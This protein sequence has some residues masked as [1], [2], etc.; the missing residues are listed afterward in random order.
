M[1]FWA[2]GARRLSVTPDPFVYVQA[3]I[4]AGN[5]NSYY[6]GNIGSRFTNMVCSG[7]SGISDATRMRVALDSALGVEVVDAAGAM[8]THLTP[9]GHLRMGDGL[10]IGTRAANAT[11]TPDRCYQLYDETA[12]L[13][14]TYI[15]NAARLQVGWAGSFCYGYFAPY[16][17]NTGVVGGQSQRWADYIG[18]KTVQLHDG[19]YLHNCQVQIP[20]A[21]QTHFEIDVR[22]WWL[23]LSGVGCTDD[24]TTN[25]SIATLISAVAVNAVWQ[26]HLK[27]VGQ[28]TWQ[29]WIWAIDG[30]TLP[31]FQW[32]EFSQAD[33]DYFKLEKGTNANTIKITTL[34]SVTAG[35][36]T[37]DNLAA[38]PAN[39]NTHHKVTMAA[40]AT[41]TK[42][43]ANNTL[44][45]TSATHPV[46]MTITMRG[47]ITA[48]PNGGVSKTVYCD[49]LDEWPGVIV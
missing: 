49:E 7:Y 36:E 21:I 9:L 40:G 13:I 6:V 47:R 25:Q 42:Y 29:A 17:D 18:S 31:T 38:N 34:N 1:E 4:Y 26:M 44:L 32:G 3:S 14:E 39:T 10:R 45:W 20:D 11:G 33:A 27:L 5:D 2:G 41:G 46:P 48:I 28:R 43:Y 16:T 22:P 12:L 8:L 30:D 24:F 37:A 19:T 23:T 35:T 15:A